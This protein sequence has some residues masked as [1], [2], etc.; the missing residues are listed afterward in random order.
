MPTFN[1]PRKPKIGRRILLI[2][3][4]FLIYFFTKHITIDGKTI[5]KQGQN[6]SLIF[7]KL[8]TMEK[9]SMKVYLFTHRSVDFSKIEPG[10]YEFSGS[11][12]KS[13]FVKSILAGPTNKYVRI[14]VLE[15]RSIYDIDASLTKKGLITQGD[16]IALVTDPTIIAKYQAKYGY[17]STLPPFNLSTLKTLEGFL[18]PDTYNIDAGGNISD[19]LVY[20]QLENFNNKIWKGNADFIANQGG[21]WYRDMI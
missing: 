2:L 18:Y 12:S 10:T 16:Y 13:A 1:K 8:S 6:A 3:I 15:G 7:N 21:E 5:I 9:A 11:Y 17:L 14:T 20:L 4:I 19:Q